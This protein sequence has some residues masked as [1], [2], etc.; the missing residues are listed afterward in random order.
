MTRSISNPR[1][2]LM[3]VMLYFSSYREG[4]LALWLV[5]A[6]G[7][8][9]VRL[10]V[11]T[12]PERGPSLSADGASLAYATFVDDPDIVL[13]D[14]KTG[15]EQRLPGVRDEHAPAIAP[16]GSAVAFISDRIRGR[17]DLWLQPL[18]QGAPA[19][20]PQRLTDRP[21]SVAQP[22]FSPDGKWIAYHRVIDGQR[23]V[24]IVAA[25][26]GTETRF[27][28]SPAVDVHPAW[29]P[30]A[31]R[32][33]FVSERAGGSHIWM[34]PVRD[35]RPAGEAAQ[36]TSGTLEDQAP[37]F[38]P[39]G[40]SIVFIRHGLR[41]EDDLWLQPLAPNASPRR[42]TTGAQAGR[43]AW[44]RTSGDLLGDRPLEWRTPYTARCLP[45]AG[46]RPWSNPRRC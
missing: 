11:G 26:G 10:T 1:G 18:A 40:K 31:S 27:T 21:G 45:T 8:T 14:R 25:G 33:A 37:S 12:G 42:I 3:A 15:S 35:G 5:S 4:T 41:G 13:Y 29:S 34:A 46:P 32:I 2:H 30:D 23:D 38:S 9:P 44:D 16:D 6:S 17:F 43:V 22:A 7:G 24:W 28:D 39:D 36:L 20:P 19:G